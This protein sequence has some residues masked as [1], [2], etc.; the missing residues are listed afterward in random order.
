MKHIL[1]IFREMLML[2][3]SY[4]RKRCQNPIL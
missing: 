4:P 1:F 3:Q 2:L